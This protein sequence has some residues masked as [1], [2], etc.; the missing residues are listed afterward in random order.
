MSTI[1]TGHWSRERF[2]PAMRQSFA[3]TTRDVPS[4]SK[5]LCVHASSFRSCPPNTKQRR[6]QALSSSVTKEKSGLLSCWDSKLEAEV[7]GGFFSLAY[8]QI[9]ALL[10]QWEW[11]TLWRSLPDTFRLVNTPADANV[12]KPMPPVPAKGHLWSRLWRGKGAAEVHLHVISV[13]VKLLLMHCEP[14]PQSC[15]PIQFLNAVCR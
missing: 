12:L 5:V 3:P 15:P 10:E 14:G 11:K 6:D 13:G 7:K 2:L 9:I 1:R 4:Q 8:S